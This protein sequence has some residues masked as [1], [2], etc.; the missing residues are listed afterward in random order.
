MDYCYSSSPGGIQ[1][2]VFIFSQGRNY[3]KDDRINGGE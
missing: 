3:E 1:V 2:I